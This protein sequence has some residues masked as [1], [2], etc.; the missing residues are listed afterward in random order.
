MISMCQIP[1]CVTLKNEKRSVYHNADGAKLLTCRNIAR[2][3]GTRR[4][5]KEDALHV[6]VSIL[7]KDAPCLTKLSFSNLHERKIVQSVSYGC[8]HLIWGVSTVHAVE[9][10]Y[11]VD[12]YTQWQEWI[13]KRHVHFAELQHLLQTRKISNE[14]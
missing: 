10:L 7:I 2:N 5:I 12:V 9:K 3:N 8:R 4:S 1:Y 11:V 6:S 14:S 13:R